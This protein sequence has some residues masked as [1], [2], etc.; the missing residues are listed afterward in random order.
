MGEPALSLPKKNEI[1]KL[2]RNFLVF[3]F[4][5]GNLISFLG[6]QIYLIALPLIV[7]AITGSP[8]SMG[9]VA[10]LE[11]LPVLLQPFAGVLSDRLNR[12]KV[13]LICDLGRCLL[14]GGLGILFTINS[15]ELWQLYSGAFL[16]GILTQLYNTSQFATVPGL[17]RKEDLQ[18]VNSINSGIFNAAVM[19]GPGLGGLIISFYHPGYALF[20]NSLS[21]LIAFIM[22]WS[23]PIKTAIREHRKNFF[24]DLK[25]GFS[26]VIRTKAILMTNLAM[27]CSIFGTTLFLTMMIFHLKDS[28][29]FNT[30]QI[31]WLLSIG[32]IGAIGGALLTNGLKKRYTYRKILFIGSSIGGLSIILFGWVD[33]YG[34]LVLA[35]GIGTAAAAT[36]SP[37]IVTIRQTLTPDHLLGRV[38]ATSRFMTWTLIPVAALVSGILAENI[39]TGYTIMIG[40]I[41]STVASI[42]YL[43]PS[44][45][46]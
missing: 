34:W 7:L 24:S 17:V 1:P 38:Q 8:I 27:I 35:N 23:I 44:L 13:L 36:M 10:A 14:V 41:L 26:F 29:H 5:G 21:F 33:T 11:R 31:G 32:G 4:M 3:R 16:I 9:I 40:G 28:L 12:K 43:H 42:I 6:D 39:G 30:L 45:S 25:E 15:L 22:I 2:K 19:V 18:A 46:K 20:V 37:C